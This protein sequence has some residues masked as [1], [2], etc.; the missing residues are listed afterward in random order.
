Y[1]GCVVLIH[2]AVKIISSAFGDDI[3]HAT[4]CLPVLRIEAAGLDLNFFDEIEIDARSKSTQSRYGIKGSAGTEL[5]IGGVDAIDDGQIFEPG[6]PRNAR[7]LHASADSTHN[8]RRY[9]HHGGE[10][11][12]QGDILR[13]CIGDSCSD[14]FGTFIDRRFCS[15]DD[16][17]GVGYLV[18]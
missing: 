1:V 3:D 16:L 18:R 4:Q 10:V 13:E 6:G 7:V 11:S 8:T 12:N 2:A 17:Y 9:K 14:R 15:R 5:G